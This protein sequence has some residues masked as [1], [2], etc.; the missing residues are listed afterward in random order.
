MYVKYMKTRLAVD[1]DKSSYLYL[2]TIQTREKIAK[3]VSHVLL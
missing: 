2:V 3:I 1:S